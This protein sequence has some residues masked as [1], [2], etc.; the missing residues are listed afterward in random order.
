MRL[1]AKGIV[2]L[3]VEGFAVA[4]NSALEGLLEQA[5]IAIPFPSFSDGRGF[6]LAKRL[7]LAGFQGK[8]IA[9]G[10]LISDQFAY[11]LSCGFDEVEVDDGVFQ[12]QPLEQW[13][14]ALERREFTYQ[15]G[16][17]GQSILAARQKG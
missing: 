6:T 14:D 1:N 11:A 13:L 3:P 17:L 5:A 4:N 9:T 12:R 8:L 10:K 7:R 2:P 16:A 15:N